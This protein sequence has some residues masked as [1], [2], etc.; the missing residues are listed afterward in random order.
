MADDVE[1]ETLR[2]PNYPAF[3]LATALERAEA[4]YKEN[5]KA[6]VTTVSA[7]KAWGYNSLNGRSLRTLAALRQFGLLEDSGPKM[8]RLSQLALVILRS[9]VPH[10]PARLGALQSAARKPTVFAS[11]FDQ[12][13]DG[14]PG[15]DAMVSELEIRSNFTGEAARKLVAAFRETLN[16]VGVPVGGDT[17]SQDGGGDV[18]NQDQS[19]ER[20]PNKV[21]KMAESGR[22][23]LDLPIPIVSGGQAIL[24]LP[25]RMTEADFAAFKGVLD[26]ML[27]GM[28]AALTAPV[29]SPPRANEGEA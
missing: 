20:K 24:R 4:F 11:L 27:Q 28:R 2:S 21:A 8:V 10:D 5:G 29:E 6:S 26:A 18:W 19:T 23:S 25:R 7:V 13:K 17:P 22:E 9:P 12:Y 16:L 3:G 14:V 15:D 1:R